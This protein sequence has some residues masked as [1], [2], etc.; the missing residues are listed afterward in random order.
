MPASMKTLGIVAHT[1][2]GGALCF[3]TACRE[4]GVYM[5]PN[6]H[7]RIILSA[8][9]FGLSLPGWEN[10]DHGLVARYLGEGVKQVADAGADFYVC[11]ANTAHIVLEKIADDLPIPGL[12]IT[13]VVCHEIMTNGWKRV[14]L[15]GTS[16]TMTGPVYVRA[17]AERGLDLL[18]P[19][20]AMRRRLN[21]AIF[22]E[23]VQGIFTAETTDLFVGAIADLKSAGAECVILGCTEIPL[24][25]TDANSPLPALDSTRLLASYAVREAVSERPLGQRTG[26][27]PVERVGLELREA[28]VLDR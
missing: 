3:L 25:V 22:G 26:W 21:A 13:D 6:M 12:S 1:F 11:P 28:T 20:E 23:L 19:D 27:L 8:V 5:G 17:L 24:I 16:Y 14:G 4:G 15:L 7:P 9:P 10:D 2:E 18:I